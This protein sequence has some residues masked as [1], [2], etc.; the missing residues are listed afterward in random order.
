MIAAGI[1][2]IQEVRL[3][4]ILTAHPWSLDLSLR[5]KR[6]I[7]D[8]EQSINVKHTNCICITQLDISSDNAAY[9]HHFMWN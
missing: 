6:M 5:H 3:D 2:S 4:E 8:M 7:L 1:I 9:K